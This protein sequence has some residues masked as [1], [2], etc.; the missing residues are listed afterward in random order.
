MNSIHKF[1]DKKLV[2]KEIYLGYFFGA[3]IGVSGLGTGTQFR[4]QPPPA[5]GQRR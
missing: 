2:L 4:S 1:Y 5:V 3:M